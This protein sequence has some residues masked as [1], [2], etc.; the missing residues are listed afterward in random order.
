MTRSIPLGIEPVEFPG[1]LRGVNRVGRQQQA[2]AKGCVADAS[3]SVDPRSQQEAQMPGL[4]RPAE[5]RNIH[6]RREPRPTPRPHHGEPLHDEGAVE[7]LQ[8]RD[9][10]HGRQRDEIQIGQQIRRRARCRPE[11]FVAQA[12]VQADQRHEDD[13]G[14]AERAEAGQVV[15]PVGIDRNRVGQDLRRLV[16]IEHDRIESELA[17]FRDR[18]V[19]GRPAI[20]GHEQ[21]R[22]TLG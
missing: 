22:A 11:A 6:E 12:A 7:A 10:G 17:R 9:V 19:R 8:R 14:R 18:L 1:D 3:A 20:D 15:L 13:A 2:R 16:M 21:L 5:P 4:R